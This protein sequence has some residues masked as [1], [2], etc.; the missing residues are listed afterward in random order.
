MASGA[1]VTDTNS[2]STI[3]L[4][5]GTAGTTASWGPPSTYPATNG[6]WNLVSTQ[7]FAWDGWNLSMELNGVN[8]AVR[9]M[10]WGL[11]LSGSEQGAGGVGGLVFMT[12]VA[13]NQTHHPTFDGN[14]NVM[15]MRRGDGVAISQHEYGPFGETLTNRDGFV[16]TNPWWFS[17]KYQ[18]GPTGLVYFGYRYYS[19]GTGRWLNRDPLDE[20]GGLNLY[21]AF[22]NDA[23]DLVDP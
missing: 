7:K 17:T 16:G 18:D 13:S 2:S 6:S 1:T 22:E 5:G 20:Q 21:D 11:D 9:S 15:S 4:E 8:A 3:N 14:G 10:G 19:P 23:M 12:E